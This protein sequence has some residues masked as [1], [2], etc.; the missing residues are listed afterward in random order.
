MTNRLRPSSRFAAPATLR[1][2]APNTGH[3]AH[4][5]E[6]LARTVKAGNP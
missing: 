1:P 5:Y 2:T 3:M 4:P 6:S